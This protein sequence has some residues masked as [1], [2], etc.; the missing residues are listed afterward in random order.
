MPGTPV[1]DEKP[2]DDGTAGRTVATTSA[3]RPAMSPRP[4]SSRTGTARTVREPG[5]RAERGV[6]ART[7]PVRC[8]P[9]S[10]PASGRGKHVPHPV[11]AGRRQQPARS[12]SSVSGRR[13]PPRAAQLH[14][15]ARGQFGAPVAELAGEPR[16][17]LQLRCADQPPGSRILA[18][19]RRPPRASRRTA[20]HRSAPGRLGGAGSGTPGLYV[21]AVQPR[22]PARR[23]H[24]ERF[25]GDRLGVGVSGFFG[26][27]AWTAVSRRTV[28]K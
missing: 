5:P 8:G 6:S 3:P 23:Q 12:R 4:S 9:R 18:M 27:V 17:R 16:E 21:T 20:G 13:R 2:V 1:A 25:A 14:V 10:S 11:V 7:I 28:P 19:T 26:L 22:P 15:A 24:V